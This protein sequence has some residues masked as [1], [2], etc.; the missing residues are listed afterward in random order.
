M[1]SWGCSG[2]KL[3]KAGLL[4]EGRDSQG[5]QVDCDV[6]ELV[7]CHKDWS[8]PGGD[9]V[10]VTFGWWALNHVTTPLS[11]VYFKIGLKG[12]VAEMSLSF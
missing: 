2:R 1:G 5:R 8:K 3:R 4:E 7:T 10:Q 11:M 6:E 9:S 12:C